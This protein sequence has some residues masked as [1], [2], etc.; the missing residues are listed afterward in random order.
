MKV[1]S[2]LHALFMIC[3]QIYIFSPVL[4]R[5]VAVFWCKSCFGGR[6]L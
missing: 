5:K 4:I 1:I 3:K 6:L 2:L